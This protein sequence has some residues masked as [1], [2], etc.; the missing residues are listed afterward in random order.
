[1]ANLAI[2]EIS[3]YINPSLTYQGLHNV[4]P[5]LFI[6]F[7]SLHFHFMCIYILL[8]HTLIHPYLYFM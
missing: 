7:D 4:S 3:H 1:M 6:Y 5:P 8:Y 2:W